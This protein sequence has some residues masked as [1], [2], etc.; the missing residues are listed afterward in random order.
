[1]PVYDYK[2]KKC[3]TEF[4]KFLRSLAA[5]STVKCEKCGS[6]QVVKLVTCCAVSAGG[7]TESGSSSN[8]SS[9]CGTCSGGTCSTCH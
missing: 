7:K 2:C 1:M 5:A 8:S 6:S 4:E 9:S 3:G